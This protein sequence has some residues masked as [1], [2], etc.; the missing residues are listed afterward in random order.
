[1]PTGGGSHHERF[2][3]WVDGLGGGPIIE[4]EEIRGY[5][6]EQAF[7]ILAQLGPVDA[8]GVEIGARGGGLLASAGERARVRGDVPAA[9]SLLRRAAALLQEDSASRPTL[10]LHA[11]EALG[12]MGDF[13]AADAL[14]SQS[15]ASAHAR[16]DRALTTTASVVRLTWRQ[17]L[18]DPESTQVERVVDAARQAIADLEALDAH[19]GLARA[20]T[21]MTHVH[22]YEGMLGPAEEAAQRA[23]GEAELAGD[24][25]LQVRLLS[26]LATCALYGPTPV[27]EA[28]RRCEDVLA[29]G[30][31]DRRT[32][33]MTLCSMSHLEAMRG[34]AVRARELYQRSRAM[35]TELG[36]TFSASLTSLTSGP[37]EMLAGDLARAETELR[38]DYAALTEMGEKGYMPS[39]A[40]LLAEV[41]YAEGRLA[42]AAGFADVCQ[43]AAAPY[44]VGAQYQ[45]RCIR[46]KLI[47]NDGRVAEA[48]DLAREAVRL[49][50]ATDQPV[51]QGEGLVSL[52][53][54]LEHAGKIPEAAAALGE[55][56]ALFEEK[57]D[58]VAAA[59]AREAI[60]ATRARVGVPGD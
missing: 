2:V 12:E 58:V 50:N 19:A 51:V 56:V 49:I 44:D 60:E 57:G 17:Q 43:Q 20:W 47:A 26:A 53:V 4:Y 30:E 35:L 48:E 55:A 1:V 37:V 25:L 54:V 29:L 52:A 46:A 14:L 22:F 8:H 27:T 28:I 23:I 15:E 3:D 32:E 18:A 10:L 41:L 31:G 6:L 13:L 5:H 34:N 38:G 59:S 24:R 36:S 45:W 42:E 9:A 39:V 7:L 40:G 11:G 21:L 16:G 33:A